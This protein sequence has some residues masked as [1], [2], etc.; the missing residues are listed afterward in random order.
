MESSVDTYY[1]SFNS[2]DQLWASPTEALTESV[3]IIHVSWSLHPA[4]QFGHPLLCILCCHS[5]TFI[6]F[7]RNVSVPIRIY[8]WCVFSRSWSRWNMWNDL[9]WENARSTIPVR[10]RTI[11]KIYS[12]RFRKEFWSWWW[13]D[14]NQRQRSRRLPHRKGAHVVTACVDMH[15]F[16]YNNRVWLGYTIESEYRRTFDPTVH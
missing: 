7:R 11:R 6:P 16:C 10:Q 9:C 14:T 15:F 13:N 8:H 4:L 2:R 3:Q 5:N 1:R 12:E